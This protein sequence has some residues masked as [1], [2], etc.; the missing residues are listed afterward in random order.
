MW[1]EVNVPDTISCV[2]LYNLACERLLPLFD[3]WSYQYKLRRSSLC[4][5][6]Q[7]RQLL[8]DGNPESVYEAEYPPEYP[9]IR[10]FYYRTTAARPT[11]FPF[12]PA[13][14]PMVYLEM[15]Y[16]VY[17]DAEI[18]R[19]KRLAEESGEEVVAS[20]ESVVR[21]VSFIILFVCLKASL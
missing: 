9:A 19:N 7:P 2:D 1:Q 6:L 21:L 16:A 15:S 10:K 4:L 20:L 12:V 14:R 3:Q 11:P 8:Y 5:W 18:W 13:K 17:V